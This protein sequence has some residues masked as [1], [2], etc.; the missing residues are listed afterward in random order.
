MILQYI[1]CILSLDCFTKRHTWLLTFASITLAYFSLFY[2]K[3]FH[4]FN[5][6][7]CIIC[8]NILL[9]KFVK[10]VFVTLKYFINISAY[11]LILSKIF[12][13]LI[14]ILFSV[15]RVQE[16]GLNVVC[17][18]TSFQARQLILDNH[19][20]LGDLETYPKVNSY[21]PSIYYF[22]ITLN[23]YKHVTLI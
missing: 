22:L 11:I 5:W 21:S 6:G 15:E 10:C 8:N 9:L 1:L 12:Y 3:K 19:L 14:R 7:L 16:E 20:T 17:V 2:Y 13:R 18:P 23:I 4:L